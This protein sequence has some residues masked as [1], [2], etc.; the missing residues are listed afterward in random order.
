MVNLTCC[1]AKADH[2][3]GEMAEDYRQRFKIPAKAKIA[4]ISTAFGE[5]PLLMKA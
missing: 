3:G 1:I 4:V 5:S 2:Y